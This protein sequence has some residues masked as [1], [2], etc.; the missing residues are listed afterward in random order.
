MTGPALPASTVNRRIVLAARP[1]GEPNESHFRLEETRMPTAQQ[2][3]VL[4]RNRFLSLDPYMRGRMSAAKSYAEPVA[5]GD[6]MVGATVAEVVTSHHPDYRVGDSV[7]GF[8]GWQDF[9]TSNGNGL[10]KLDPQTAPVTTALGVLGMPGMTAYTGLLTIG[11]PK[12]GETVAVA[13]A[14][15]PVGSLVGQIAK[16][17]GARAV[18]IA[19]GP[20]KC[21]YLTEHLGFDAAIDHRS[22]SFA[23]DL[24]AAC[25]KGIDVYFENVGGAVFDAV[26][27]LLNT[28]ARLPVCGLVSGYSATDLPAGPDRIPLLMR[29]VLSKRLHL[30]GFIVWDFASQEAAF[31]D[32][33]GGWLRDGRIRHRED[34]VDGLE[35]A[36]EAFAGLLKGRNFGK[37]I[38][39]IA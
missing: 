27:P 13:A 9:Y 5:I 7:V 4:L 24:A 8:G 21:A 17:K 20:K 35:A 37:L 38:V 3:E 31:L 25:P 23:D 12:P 28:F 15:G 16:L 33:V 36:P 29:A 19:G 34:I 1:H 14:T 26:L 18:G 2:G 39:K 22:E 10:R 30:Q 11:R 32:A 6:T